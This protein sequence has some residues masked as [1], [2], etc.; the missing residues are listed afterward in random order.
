[1][2][3]IG[4]FTQGLTQEAV[5]QHIASTPETLVRALDAWADENNAAPTEEEFQAG[6]VRLVTELLPDPQGPYQ[7]LR[8]VSSG[9]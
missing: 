2:H 3:I 7:H 6:Q 8:H 1:M 9:N 4:A 5:G